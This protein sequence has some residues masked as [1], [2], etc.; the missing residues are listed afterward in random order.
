MSFMTFVLMV[1][2]LKGIGEEFN[3]ELI[4]YYTRN[5][6]IFAILEVFL[7][8]FILVVGKVQSLTFFDLVAFLNYKFVGLC[9]ILII[10]LLFGGIVTLIVK[11]YFSISFVY[12]MMA[13]LKVH[14]SGIALGSE[15]GF[16][17]LHSNT[18][19]YLLSGIQFITMW[20]L[21]MTTTS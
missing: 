15:L 17:E 3:P 1:C 19:I 16:K 13:E 21:T 6:I 2:L 18:V 20:M 4:S 11:L 10:D 7:Y 5:C 8:K 9:F 12:Y 14:A